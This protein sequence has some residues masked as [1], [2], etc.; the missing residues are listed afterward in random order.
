M[1]YLETIKTLRRSKKQNEEIAKLIRMLKF[2][3]LA[4]ALILQLT[5]PFR[6]F[7]YDTIDSLGIDT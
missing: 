7:T 6:S 4:C 1:L 3:T 5:E 2:Q